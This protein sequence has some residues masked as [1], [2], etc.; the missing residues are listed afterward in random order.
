MNTEI[1][2]EFEG[3]RLSAYLDS[4]NV[5]T[6]GYGHT[7]GVVM[8]DTCTQE[9]AEAFLMSD[10]HSAITAVENAVTVD[11]TDEEEGA[12]VDLVFNIGA[13]NFQHSTLLRLL[14]AGD[15]AGAAE[16]FSQWNHAGALVLAG[17]TR[18]R[19]AEAALF[20][21]GMA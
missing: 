14:N 6:I 15:F 10:L 21:E 2:K 12:L 17:L 16:Q 8:G 18:R 1:E 5:P 9:E 7:K 13:G 20:K 3:C 19:A 11:L 4:V